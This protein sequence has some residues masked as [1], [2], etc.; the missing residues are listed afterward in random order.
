MKSA[1]PGLL[2]KFETRHRLVPSE[3]TETQKEALAQLLQEGRVVHAGAYYLAGHEPSIETERKKIVQTLL[4]R[5]RLFKENSLKPKRKEDQRY[6]RSALSELI[7]QK[8]VIQLA[9]VGDSKSACFIHREHLIQF[10]GDAGVRGSKEVDAGSLAWESGKD[11]TAKIRQ[12]YSRVAQEKERSSIFIADLL[13]ASGMSWDELHA[14]IEREVVQA[15]HGQLD[16]GDWGAATDEQRAA[17]IELS[18]RKRL[19]IALS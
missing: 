19:Y 17:A 16:E 8:Q 4:S 5:P 6:F 15:G 3:I 14:W 12:A 18:G 11:R 9:I 13:K 10:F 7:D 1:V 2:K